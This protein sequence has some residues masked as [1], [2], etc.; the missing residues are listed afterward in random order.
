M[1]DNTVGRARRCVA[2][3]IENVPGRAAGNGDQ[4]QTRSRRFLLM[5]DAISD[6]N[7]HRHG[8]C[9]RS[10]WPTTLALR[11]VASSGRRRRLA[12]PSVYVTLREPLLIGHDPHP[13]AGRGAPHQLRKSLEKLVHTVPPIRTCAREWTR[14]RAGLLWIEREAAA[15]R[16]QHILPTNFRYPADKWTRDRST[17]P[18][19]YLR[20]DYD[21]RQACP[22]RGLVHSSSRSRWKWSQAVAIWPRLAVAD[23]LTDLAARAISSPNLLD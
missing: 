22:I 16:C 19:Q 21:C 12:R 1:C 7:S 6:G 4:S 15:V 20:P 9:R 17:P 2:R 14:Q 23:P 18:G 5:N 3:V 10:P 13:S 8:R 11:G